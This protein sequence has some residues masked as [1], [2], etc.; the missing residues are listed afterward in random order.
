[1][2]EQRQQQLVNGLLQLYQILQTEGQSQG[3]F[4]G[5]DSFLAQEILLGL[6]LSISA[7]MDDNHFQITDNPWE[8]HGA[9]DSPTSQQLWQSQKPE[10]SSLF[11]SD[12]S[13]LTFVSDSPYVQMDPNLLLADLDVINQEGQ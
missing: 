4:P 11:R 13:S 7:N 1:L 5:L 10:E 8:G 3:C 9:Q 12:L 6:G 2:L